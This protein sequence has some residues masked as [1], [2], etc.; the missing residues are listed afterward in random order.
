MSDVG[1]DFFDDEFGIMACLNLLAGSLVLLDEKVTEVQESLGE[2]SKR[3]DEQSKDIE[4]VGWG[5]TSLEVKIDELNTHLVVMKESL[6]GP[7]HQE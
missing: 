5:I 6:S 3:F 1:G 7:D 2:V 4:K